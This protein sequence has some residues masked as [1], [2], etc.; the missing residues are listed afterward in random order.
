NDAITCVNQVPALGDSSA[1]LV[2]SDP[3]TLET[4]PHGHGDVHHL[5][6]REGVAEK[7]KEGGFE[8][9]FFFQDTNALVWVSPSVL[10]FFVFIYA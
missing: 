9:L 8:W 10:F 2:L 6:L 4:K 5:L 7:L 3:F 1:S